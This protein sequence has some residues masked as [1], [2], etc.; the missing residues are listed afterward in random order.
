MTPVL[1]F[2]GCGSMNGSILRGVLASGVPVEQIRATVRSEDSARPLREETG[3]RAYVTGEDPEA[4]RRAAREADVVLLGVKPVGILD[5][6]RE[7]APALRPGT[8]VAS[9]A[10][11][12]SL[13]ALE[14]VLPAGQ[15]VVR[16]MPNTPSSVGR[17][18]VSVTPG[19]ATT[20]EQTRAV[21]RVLEAV[22]T[23]VEVPEE[24]VDAVTGVSGSGPAYVFLLAEA[25]QHAGERMGLPADVA[26][27]LA[28]ETVSGAGE[29]LRPAG[30]DP[31]ALRKAVTSPKG[32]TDRAITTFQENGF[33]DLV[34]AAARASADRSAELTR[35]FSA[36]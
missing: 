22:G 24:Q 34:A 36:G 14:Q 21:R 29:L 18:V 27:V 20:P 16:T 4:N 15:P 12:I 2:L 35:E 9:V 7:I 13:E 1:A 11:G 30:A 32:T 31:A 33:E 26:R 5:L 6:A 23:V 8:V 17:G 19:T 10:A 28:K 3:V 25:M